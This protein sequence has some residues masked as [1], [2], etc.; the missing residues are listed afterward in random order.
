MSGRDVVRA[1]RENVE[2]N[3]PARRGPSL[4]MVLSFIAL[5]T[6]ICCAW[7]AIDKFLLSG[8]HPP[9]QPS[10]RMALAEHPV[11][12]EADDTSCT[13]WVRKAR[14]EDNPD[15]FPLANPAITGGGYVALTANLACR[16][17][18]KV[19]R[20]CDAEQKAELVALVK[21][22][23]SR[24][25]IIS[26]GLE[27]QGAPMKVMGSMVGGEVAFGSSV[28]DMTM[29]ETLAYMDFHHQRVATS[30]RALATGGILSSDDFSFH[31]FGVPET[32]AKIFDGVAVTKP[33]CG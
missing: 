12:E 29:Q 11:W 30:L 18:V 26:L 25:D 27:V 28:Y 17:S 13:R 2:L 1:M 31:G 20:L 32:L 23:M 15:D 6:V 4:D 5:A 22:Y 10:A 33:A 9:Q 16:A 24:R 3:K 19:A 21:D 7:V 8:P 14:A